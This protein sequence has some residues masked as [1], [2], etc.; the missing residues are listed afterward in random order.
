MSYESGGQLKTLD[1]NI[2]PQKCSLGENIEHV[3]RLE[4]VKHLKWVLDNWRKDMENC[5][6]VTL[7]LMNKYEKCDGD[8]SEGMQENLKR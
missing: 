1:T 5:T 7:D 2:I 6:K 8:F 4:V 3:F